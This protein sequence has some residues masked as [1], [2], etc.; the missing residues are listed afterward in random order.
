[1]DSQIAST[2]ISCPALDICAEYSS[3]WRLSGQNEAHGDVAQASVV[4]VC[5]VRRGVEVGYAVTGIR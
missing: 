4:V 1:M 2:V 5:M 3:V